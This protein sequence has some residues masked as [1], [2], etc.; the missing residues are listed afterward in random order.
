MALPPCYTEMMTLVSS[1]RWLAVAIL[2][3]ACLDI[4]EAVVPEKQPEAGASGSAGTGG[5]SSGG[6][7]GQVS[8]TCKDGIQNGNE[9]GVDC[10]GSCPACPTCK[11]GI[12]NG[13]ELGVDCG[14]NICPECPTCKDGIKNGNE[15]GVDCGGSCP[16][17]PTCKDGI[18]N[19]NELGVDCGGSCPACPTCKDGIK[20]GNELGVDC[21]G[22]CAGVF[23]PFQCP[24]AAPL[25]VTHN[26]LV[27]PN[28][29]NP[30]VVPYT[31]GRGSCPSLKASIDNC[32]KL[33][34]LGGHHDP[35]RDCLIRKIRQQGKFETQIT[36]CL[37]PSYSQTCMVNLADSAGAPKTCP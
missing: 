33:P 3:P 11:D 10:G 9:K 16:A 31:D 2:L 17:C 26:W 37:K 7:G 19:G 18:K 30:C 24:T 36:N 15:L 29:S 12:K 8:P 21:G 32:L 23:C 35:R 5:Q 28:P 20:N 6:T 34:M 22:S 14:G 25:P 13:N 4:S 1:S 27:W